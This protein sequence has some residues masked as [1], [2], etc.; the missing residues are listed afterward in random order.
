LVRIVGQDRKQYVPLTKDAVASSKYDI[1]I[2]DAPT[3]P[4]EKERTW[5]ILQVMLPMVKELVTPEVLMEVLPYTP[6]PAS[7]VDKLKQ[8]AQQAAQ[9]PKPPSPE[10]QKM[11]LEQQKA[12]IDMAGKQADLQV[13][14]AKA[15]VDVQKSGIDLMVAQQQAQNDLAVSQQKLELQAQ[16]NALKAESNRIM[17]QN[18]DSKRIKAAS[19]Q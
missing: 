9:Q 6:L 10:E 2:D 11:Q 19:G 1:I 16:Q 7:F 17:A 13:H 5:Q 3:S 15:Q 12:Q 4:N 18:A 14:Q 8:Q